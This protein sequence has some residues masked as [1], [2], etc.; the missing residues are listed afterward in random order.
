MDVDALMALVQDVV[1]KARAVAEKLSAK[2]KVADLP[3]TAGEKADS[4]SASSSAMM[5]ASSS[6]KQEQEPAAATIKAVDE[7][8]Y[9]AAMRPLQYG[10]IP[11]L[12]GYKYEQNLSSTSAGENVKARVKR[13][14]SFSSCRP[15]YSAASDTL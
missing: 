5:A 7:E 2:A 13:L 11:K 14:V 15:T 9:V 8:V 6:S 10:E 3:G 4:G 12:S 1:T